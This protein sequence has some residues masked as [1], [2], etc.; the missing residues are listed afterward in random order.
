M[1]FKKTFYSYLLIACSLLPFI[2]CIQLG[3]YE[4]NITIPNSSWKSGYEVK[5]SF[6]IKDSTSKFIIYLVLR[7]RDNYR[8]NNIWLNVGLQNPGDTMFYQKVD[9]QLGND[10][11]G[12]KGSGMNDIWELREPLFSPPKNFR[13]TGTYNFSIKQIMRDDPLPGIMSAGLRLEKQD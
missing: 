6:D 13:K 10:A 7:H 11:T 1:L 3:L 8:Y 5:G 12:W 2:S 9:V 4:K